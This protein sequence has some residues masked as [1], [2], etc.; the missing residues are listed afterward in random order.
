MFSGIDLTAINQGTIIGHM[1]TSNI[2]TLT[3]VMILGYQSRATASNQVR[4]GNSN[5]TSIGGYAGWT[6]IS[7]SRYKTNVQ[8]NVAGLDFIL[9]LRPVTY[10]LDMAK[11]AADLGEDTPRTYGENKVMNPV[12][13]FDLQSR[14]EKSGMLYTGFIAQEVETAAQQI[15]FAFSGVDAP[16]NQSDFYG[17]R[18][19]EFV[20]PLV[21]A[22]QEQQ[23][24]IESQQKVIN[25]LLKRIEALEADQ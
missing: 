4:I 25:D 17:L 7:D 21:K 6:N 22:V 10:N 2:T 15:G 13:D 11:L 19:A 5:V 14:A 9:K 20:V 18:Y 23:A 1:A 3:N 12:T 8:D 16:K 24:M